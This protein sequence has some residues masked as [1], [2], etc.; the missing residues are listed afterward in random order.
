MPKPWRKVRVEA[1]TAATRIVEA[2]RRKATP[3][4]RRGWC[5]MGRAHREG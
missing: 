4:L 3:A 5:F 2:D 1:D